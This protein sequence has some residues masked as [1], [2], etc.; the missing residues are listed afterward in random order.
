MYPDDLP[1]IENKIAE[2]IETGGYAELEHRIQGP[3]GVRWV[4]SRGRLIREE[5]KP[6][7][8]VGINMDIAERPFSKMSF[9]N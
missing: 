6:T 1:A 8:L 9:A 7:R 5:G 4:Y 3:N 2:V